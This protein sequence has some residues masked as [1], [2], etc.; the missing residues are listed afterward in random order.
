MN[1]LVEREEF[2]ANSTIG[3]LLIDGEFECYTL[4]DV[5]RDGPKVMHQTA[6]PEGTYRVIINMSN[7]FKRELP[8]LM[9]VPGFE[10]IRIHPGNTSEDTSGC[11]LLGTSK[12]TDLLGSSR[13][14]FNPFFDKLQRAL[15]G[16][17]QVWITV[18]NKC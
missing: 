5:V 3:R 12:G 17:S 7:R 16:E 15:Q 9:G 13:L 14:A 8:L 1:L 6:I 11:I 2:T 10:G 4:E 18:R